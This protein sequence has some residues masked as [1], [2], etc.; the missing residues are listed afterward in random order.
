LLT[1]AATA[2]GEST[3][4]KVHAAIVNAL[5]LAREDSEV[6]AA[7]ADYRSSGSSAQVRERFIALHALLARRGVPWSR[8]AGATLATRVLRPGSSRATDDLI[9]ELHR[10]WDEIESLTGFD[11]DARVVAFAL[12]NDLDVAGAT[13]LTPPSSQEE[14]W[15]FSQ[16]YGLIWP[17]G[18]E[19]RTAT[20]D[21]YTPFASLPEP[22][23]LVI[24]PLLGASEA[25]V[26]VS[27]DDWR[28]ELDSVLVRDGSAL[29][30]A[31]GDADGEVKNVL[32]DILSRPTDLGFLHA[33]PRVVGVATSNEASEISVVLD[34]AP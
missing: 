21:A 10:R 18:F 30:V 13:G 11:A 23:R 26:D 20:L 34:E 7:F 2:I 5:E 24:G 16:I 19:A 22:E 25:R 8:S 32:L 1:L 14:A 12:R 9:L 27:L 33:Y 29:L 6:G 28:E 3:Y 15:R 4:E 31:G 17:R